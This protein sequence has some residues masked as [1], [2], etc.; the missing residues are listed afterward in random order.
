MVRRAVL[1]AFDAQR[2]TATLQVV[3]SP[4]VW[5]QGVPV[6]RALPAAELVVGREVAVVFTERG[7]PAA[8]LV[9]GLW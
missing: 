9:I 5:L 1:Q 3:G 8:A 7:D 6:S 2:Y 4:T